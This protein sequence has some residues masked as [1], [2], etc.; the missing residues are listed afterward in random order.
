MQKGLR[1][2]ITDRL[3]GLIMI[4]IGLNILLFVSSGQYWTLLNP[5]YTMV[6]TVT[7]Y[8]CGLI[9]LIL[10]LI[11]ATLQRSSLFSAVIILGLLGA[12]N[13]S[14]WL[15]QQGSSPKVSLSLEEHV[16]RLFSRE[17][18][19]DKEYIKINIAELT[20]L[21]ENNSSQIDS[22][23][24]LFRGQIYRSG[25]GEYKV[26]RTAVACCLADAISI[27]LKV[28]T[29]LP[30]DYAD[31][32]WVKVYG[33]ITEETKSEPFDSHLA[34]ATGFMTVIQ[35]GVIFQADALKEIDMPDLPMIFQ[36]HQQEP[37][38]Y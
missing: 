27:G 24:F 26:L 1:Q 17:K 7:G 33:H 16:D 3:P 23:N 22:N 13:V 15:N 9:G 31:G 10:V 38:V 28:R 19:F 32:Q 11:P 2:K 21:I 36:F 5:K 4:L 18:K 12:L 34:K 8:T 29:D 14:I 37:F 35:P 6:T 25:A 30:V 20:T